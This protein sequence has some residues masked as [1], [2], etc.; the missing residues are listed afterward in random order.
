MLDMKTIV[1][2][3]CNKEKQNYGKGVCNTCYHKIWAR[4]QDRKNY[5]AEYRK[6]NPNYFRSKHLYYTFGITLEKYEIML[7]KQGGLCAICS[8][9]CVSGKNLAVDHCHETGK[10]R[11]LLCA[12]CNRGIGCF[13]DKKEIVEKALNYLQIYG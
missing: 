5:R 2:L 11:G 4:K 10:I 6:E 7:K 1:C 12:N 13:S 3:E 9:V 8:K